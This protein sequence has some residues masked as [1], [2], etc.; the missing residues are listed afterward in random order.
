MNWIRNFMRGRYG[1]DQLGIALFIASMAIT[2]V[3]S[4][5]G[6]TTAWLRLLGEIPLILFLFRILSRNTMKR[7]LENGRFLAI[8]NTVS[9]KFKN[10]SEQ[11]R[12]SK[13]H[14]FIKCTNCRQTLRLPRGRGKIRVTCPKCGKVF[15]KKT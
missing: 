13:T 11:L 8:W 12:D 3:F 4:F 2:L 15:E 6:R 5:G 7:Q 1:L 9:S 14:I 10:K